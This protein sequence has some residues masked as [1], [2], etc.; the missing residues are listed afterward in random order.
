M[1]RPQLFP[2]FRKL[3]TLIFH[4]DGLDQPVSH[5]THPESDHDLI[6]QNPPCTR[7]LFVNAPILYIHNNDRYN[8]PHQ[9]HDQTAAEVQNFDQIIAQEGQT[10]DQNGS[11]QSSTDQL[12]I[13]DLIK[14]IDETFPIKFEILYLFHDRKDIQWQE[15]NL[16]KVETPFL[17]QE[18]IIGMVWV[19]VKCH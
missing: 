13:F 14:S 2:K 18:I 15:H 10:H 11:D 16:C 12:P 4:I 5:K 19:I 9:G 17:N 7:P 1:T 6:M 8:E 3:V